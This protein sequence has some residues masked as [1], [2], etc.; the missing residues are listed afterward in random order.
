MFA[1]RT[2]GRLG[3]TVEPTR[4]RTFVRQI[5]TNATLVFR[6]RTTNVRGME[7]QSIFGCV[8]AGFERAEQRLLGAQ[9]LYGRRRVLG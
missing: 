3:E 9:N 4:N 7:E 2:D 6:L 1:I 8:A 5:S